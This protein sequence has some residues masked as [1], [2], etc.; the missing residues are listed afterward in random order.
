MNEQL[1]FL[2]LIVARLDSSGIQ[3]MLTGSLALA[4]YARPRMTRDIDLVVECRARD[5]ETIVQLFETDCYVEAQE[6]R[7]AIVSR[8]IFNIIHNEWIVKADFIVRKDGEYRRLEFERRRRFSVEGVPVWVV[9]A[10]DL[11]L[12]K[13]F[14]ARDTGSELQGEDARVLVQTAEGLDW[15]YLEQWAGKLGVTALLSKLRTK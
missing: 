10:E 12:S 5:A 1:E 7:D 2:K 11:V 9:S 8:S 4:L 14:W 15:S 6:V 13:L 3:Y